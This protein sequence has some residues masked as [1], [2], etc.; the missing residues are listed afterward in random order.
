MQKIDC[1]VNREPTRANGREENRHRQREYHAIFECMATL[2]RI[3]DFSE[4]NWVIESVTCLLY[5]AKQSHTRNIEPQNMN[6][7]H[8]TTKKMVSATTTAALIM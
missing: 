8:S 3:F 4:L 6:T 1:T 7:Q 2:I 5:G